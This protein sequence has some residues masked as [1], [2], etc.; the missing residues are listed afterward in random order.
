[1]IW[2]NPLD[3]ALAPGADIKTQILKFLIK[4]KLHKII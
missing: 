1:M 3:A 4:N 2:D